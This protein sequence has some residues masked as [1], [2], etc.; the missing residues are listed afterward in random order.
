MK[1]SYTI[2]IYTPDDVFVKSWSNASIERFVKEINGGLGECVINL[3]EKFDY[4][5][6]ELSLGNR[7]DIYINDIEGQMTEFLIYRGYISLIEP[8][9]INKNEGIRAV[10]LGYHTLLT[11]DYLKNSNTTTLFSDTSAGLTTSGPGT[12]SDIG[13]MMR[14]VIDRYRA[15]NINPKLSYTNQSIPLVPA[16]S[17]KFTFEQRFYREAMDDILGLAPEN[18]FYFVD[19]NGIIHFKEAPT[20]PTWRFT[21]GR[22]IS[23]IQV[24]SNIEKLRNF[25]LVWNGLAGGP[26]IYKAYSDDLSIAR[27]GKRAER[28]IDYGIQDQSGA[29]AVGEKFLAQNKNFEARVIV[30]LIDDETDDRGLDIDKIEPGQTIMFLNYNDVFTDIFRYNL[31][32][33]EV[34]YFPNIPHRVRVKAELRR[35]GIADLQKKT[36]RKVDDLS[37]SASIPAAWT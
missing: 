29:D 8:A 1:K 21:F 18:Y 15:E 23:L 33:T 36:N 20:T 3:G 12:A 35:S 30:E 25:V 28:I 17:E 22:N 31:V 9:V 14:A 32:I 26:A 34:V 4:A 24:N 37:K 6:A 11:L 5:G 19:Q 13:L 27:Y 16:V 2:K 7:A 10:V